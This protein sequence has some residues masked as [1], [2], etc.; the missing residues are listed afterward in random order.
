MTTLLKLQRIFNE[1]I[2]L[3]LGK[4][5]NVG[6]FLIN[7]KTRTNENYKFLCLRSFSSCQEQ[8]A[9]KDDLMKMWQIKLCYS[10]VFVDIKSRIYYIFPLN[11]A[12]SDFICGIQANSR[13]MI[14]TSLR[15]NGSFSKCMR[16]L[17]TPLFALFNIFFQHSSR[18]L[19][20]NALG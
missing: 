15:E 11:C 4:P 19:T 10:Q 20:H 17:S 5:L 2:T 7:W 16:Q 3:L 18:K 14:W 1:R 12:E 13:M 6:N 8:L 9:T